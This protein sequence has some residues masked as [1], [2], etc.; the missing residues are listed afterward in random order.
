MNNYLSLNLVNGRLSRFS[1][2]GRPTF[3][4]NELNDVQIYLLDYPIPVTYPVEALGDAFSEITTRDF[5]NQVLT[6]NVGARGQNKIIST[7]SFFNLPTNIISSTTSNVFYINLAE[8]TST[9]RANYDVKFSVSPTPIIGSLFSF[10]ATFGY[11]GSIFSNTSAVFSFEN[12]ISEIKNILSTVIYDTAVSFYTNYDSGGSFINEF[13]TNLYQTSD[14]S[15][16]FIGNH[17]MS[18]VTL[19]PTVSFNVTLNNVSASSNPGKYGSLD[20]SSLNWNSVIG[21]KKEV[22]IWMEAMIDNETI[23]QGNAILC[24]KMT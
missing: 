1:G 11:G 9:I 19:P 15:F 7:T 17:T 10:T 23:A 6:I 22:P 24:R 8:G 20:F 14:Y 12:T 2:G 18:F 21:T 13:T 16:S 4:L 3:T 5:N